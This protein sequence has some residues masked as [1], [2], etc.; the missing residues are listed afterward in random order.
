VRYLSPEWFDAAGDALAADGAL[1]DALTGI[2]L[3]IE[4]VVGGSPAGTAGS[5]H[6]AIDHGRVTLV[7]GP[8]STPDLRFTTSYE[9]ATQI[10]SGAL[11]AQ[12][13]F[14]EGRLRVGG[15]LALLITHQRAVAAVDDALASVRAR[16]TYR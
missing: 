10:A 7:A 5:W 13:A 15:D 6:L 9:T 2:S 11:A 1:T 12:R 8:A 3:T 4:Q 16:T 14:V